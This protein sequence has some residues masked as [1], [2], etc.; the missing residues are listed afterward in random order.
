MARIELDNLIN[1][2]DLGGMLTSDG[3]KIKK[4]KLIRSGQLFFASEKDKEVLV[5]EY[6]LSL[7]IDF[8]SSAEKE[9]K[10]DP[11]MPGIN[12]V[13]NPIMKEITKGIT[14]DKKSDND[15]VKMI[16]L[17]MANDVKRAEKYME[18]IYESILNSDYALSQYAKFIDLLINNENGATLWHCT[19]GKDRAGFATFLVLECLG[20]DKETIIQDYLLTNEYTKKDV[21]KMI[22][23]IKK[24]YVYPLIDQVVKALFGI[25]REYLENIYDS[26]DKEYGN[27]HNFLYTKIG[28]NDEKIAKMRKMFLEK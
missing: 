16:V 17:D 19:A 15:T 6:N 24:E 26:I 21:N 27:M 23:N 7:V 14:R 3:H 1:T 28:L 2:R 9:E 22:D 25:K 8:R 10:P 13:F 5:N 20:V 4:H 12:Y 11:A 18:D